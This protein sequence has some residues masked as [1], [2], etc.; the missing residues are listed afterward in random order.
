[1]PVSAPHENMVKAN[2][3]ARTSS[4][5][6]LA[7]AKSKEITL[8]Q[9]VLGQTLGEGEFGKVKLGWRKDGGNQVSL[10]SN[11]DIARAKLISRWQS[12]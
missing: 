5:N 2:P 6:K 7:K 1:M 9:Y 4:L 8:G 11:R 3:P 10:A 12:K